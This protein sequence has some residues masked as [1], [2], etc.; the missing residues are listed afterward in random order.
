MT[1][2][3]Q[4]P[5]LVFRSGRISAAVFRR[6][7]ERDGRMEVQRQI[8]VQKRIKGDDGIWRSTE[9]YFA[10]ELP[11]LEAVVRKAYDFLVLKEEEPKEG[12]AREGQQ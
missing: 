4:M 3:K 1:E 12:R 9:T 8:C 10:N 7:A 2:Q 5:E 11:R 6:E